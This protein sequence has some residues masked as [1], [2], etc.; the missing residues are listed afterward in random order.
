M[1]DAIASTP[2]LHIACSNVSLFQLGLRPSATPI[3]GRRRRSTN[4]PPRDCRGSLS[5]TRFKLLR[6]TV[7]G[8]REHPK[9]ALEQALADPMV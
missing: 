6:R 3:F 2:Q 7:R 4:I 5:V 8:R 1:T 9:Y